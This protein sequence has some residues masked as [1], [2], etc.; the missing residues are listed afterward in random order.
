MDTKLKKG[1]EFNPRTDGKTEVVNHKV[2]HLLWGY[3]GK[4]PN[5]WDEKLPYVQHAYNRAMHSST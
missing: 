1:M 5:L 4:H 3:C 2:L